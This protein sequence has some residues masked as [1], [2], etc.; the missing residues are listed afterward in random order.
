MQFESGSKLSP[1]SR[2]FLNLLERLANKLLGMNSR[3]ESIPGKLPE[4]WCAVFYCAAHMVI[5]FFH[6]PWYDEA[7]A[8]Q[9]AKCASIKDILFTI[10]H[11][12]G[13]PQL[14]H[15]ILVPFAKLGM[16]YELSLSIVSLLF[17]GAAIILILWF[18]PFPRIFRLL[19]PF[20]YFFFY[21]YS[22]ISRPYCVMML[23][24]VLLAMAYG[25]R[26]ERPHRYVLCLMLLCLT[27]A[28]GIVLAGGLALVWVW[29]IL[30]EQGFCDF[31]KHFYRDKR[32]WWLAALLALALFL[33]ASILPREDTY[34][35][36]TM[37]EK[38]TTNNLLVR[39][40]YMVFILPSDVTLT[41]V[42]SQ[43]VFLRNALL[44]PSLMV[45]AFAIGIVIWSGIIYIG[46]VK[47]TALLFCLP[48][49]LFGGFSSAVYLSL[50]HT[51]I[52]LLFLTFWLWVTMD[53]PAV[54]ERKLQFAESFWHSVRNFA[55]VLTS[56]MMLVSLEWGVS[57]S[58][59]DIFL[60]YA[61]GRNEAAFLSENGLD[62]Y[63]IMI[64]WQWGYDSDDSDNPDTREL[65]MDINYCPYMDNVAAY[66]DHNIFYNFPGGST[67]QNYTSHRRASEEETDAALAAWAEAD[68]P[69]V[70]FMDVPLHLLSAG[71]KFSINDYA[72][73][74]EGNVG[75]IWK[76]LSLAG[77]SK[78][79]VRRELCE[80]KNL[81]ELENAP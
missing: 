16:P 39:L 8:W 35:T 70:L 3:I 67:E 55:V 56:L 64:A 60:T 75:K 13:H 9:I 69:D 37:F 29:E 12:E 5:S 54:W 19:L 44:S 31:V 52:A 4:I 50:H 79:Y 10:P 43:D 23:S 36:S 71:E 25:A 76:G 34:A 53:A 74:Y 38:K 27:S 46:R 78:I 48:Y 42:Y 66:F 77:R 63:R 22:V 68:A 24:F 33:I 40:V 59:A 62:D 15:L 14:W 6:E 51:G 80:P 18:A 41:N 30:R 49:L 17:S 65:A 2:R 7:V 72:L 26:N 57:S 28:Y 45:S 21:Q 61:V 1:V 11:Y 73:V 32:V 20:T 58:V 81:P 47:G